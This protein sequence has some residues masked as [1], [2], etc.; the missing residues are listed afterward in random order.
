M[1]NKWVPLLHGGNED[2]IFVKS[3]TGQVV[4]Q[5]LGGSNLFLLCKS[6]YHNYLCREISEFSP[7]Y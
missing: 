4:M 7:E 1:H 6:E 3:G 5:I 2:S